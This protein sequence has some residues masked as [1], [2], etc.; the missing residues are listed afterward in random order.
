VPVIGQIVCVIRRKEKW[1]IAGVD[2]INLY[3]Q[4]DKMS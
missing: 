1:K 4:I 3:N 2:W